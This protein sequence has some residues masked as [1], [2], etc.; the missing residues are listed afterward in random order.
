MSSPQAYPA[1]P[2][3]GRLFGTDGIRGVAGEFPMDRRTAYALGVALGERLTVMGREAEVVLGMDTRESG[4]WLAAHVAGGLRRAGARVRFAGIVSTPAIAFLT[5]RQGFAAGV[6]VSASHNP[7]RDNGIKIFGP[8]GYKLADDEEAFIEQ[9]VFALLERD[10]QPE[11]A[12]LQVETGLAETYADFLAASLPYV[13]DGLRLAVDCA[14]GAASV[15]APRLFERLGARVSAIGCAPDGRNINQGCGALDVEPLRAHVLAQSADLGVA[16]DGDADRAIFVTGDGRVVDGDGV[17]WLAGLWLHER[18]RLKGN[19]GPT[20][21]ATV[22]SNLGLEKALAER[23]IRLVRTAVGDKYVLEEMLR[24]GAVLGGEQSGHVIFLEYATTGDGLL[25]ALR[26]L[27]IVQDRGR[28]LREL[29]QELR[30]YPQKLVNVPVRERR[31]FEQLPSVLNAIREAEL[32]LGARGRIF[33]RYSGTELL[34]RVM[35]EG[36]DPALVS[37]LAAQVAA[38]LREELGRH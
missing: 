11:S 26:V 18:G 6:V 19:A 20:I 13:L 14:H 31:P 29:T 7:Y 37:A 24:C 5:R 23:G 38:A 28:S 30:L 36:E 21:V 32:K 35:V 16:F 34:A 17:L 33:V 1:F 22:M 4:P 10:L 9:R 3:V 12:E 27:E 2:H 25:T 15:L 8:S